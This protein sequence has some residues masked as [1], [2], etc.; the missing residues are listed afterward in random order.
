MSPGLRLCYQVDL[1]P[2]ATVDLLAAGERHA[3]RLVGDQRQTTACAVAFLSWRCV[4]CGHGS[5]DQS[6]SSFRNSAPAAARDALVAVCVGETAALLAFAPAF[7]VRPAWVSA[8][9]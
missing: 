4:E 6:S 3:D 9:V 8:G 5:D 1:E 2:D 7:A